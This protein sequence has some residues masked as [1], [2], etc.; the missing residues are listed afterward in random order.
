MQCGWDVL[1][2]RRGRRAI[3]SPQRNKSKPNLNCNSHVLA[4]F[5]FDSTIHDLFPKLL[6]LVSFCLQQCLHSQMTSTPVLKVVFMYIICLHQTIVHFRWCGFLKNTSIFSLEKYTHTH[7]HNPT[8]P[9]NQASLYHPC[10]FQRQSKPCFWP[11]I[12]PW[13]SESP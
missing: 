10:N 8:V 3:N 13:V 12:F 1:R 9:S 5:F 6:R 4:F 11:F 2:G 7:T